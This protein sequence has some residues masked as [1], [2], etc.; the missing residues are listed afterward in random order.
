MKYYEYART[1]NKASYRILSELKQKGISTDYAK[2]VIEKMKDDAQYSETIVDDRTAA[3]NVGI[4]MDRE[5]RES[6]KAADEKFYARVGR[7]LMTLGYNSGICYY[8]IGRIRSRL[9]NDE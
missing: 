3:L 7:R 9:S 2:A 5:R 8:V 6:G 1:K 4:K